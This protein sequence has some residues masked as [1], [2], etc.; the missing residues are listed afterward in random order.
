MR[1]D[2]LLLSEIIDAAQRIINLV[3]GASAEDLDL[4]RDQRE[5]LLWNSPCSAKRSLS[6]PTAPKRWRDPVRL[7]NRIVH[8]YW[9]VDLEILIAAAHDD[10]PDF[11]VAVQAVQAIVS[12]A[13]E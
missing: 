2:Q 11:L 13:E 4:N 6:C 1:R 10:L 12:A 8:G 3:S 7:R 9:S 5:A